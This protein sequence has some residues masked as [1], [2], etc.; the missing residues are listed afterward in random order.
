MR[1]NKFLARAGIASR[2]KSDELIQMATTTVN[3]KVCLDPAYKVDL[4]D[5]ICFD[6]KK[7]VISSKK[8]VLILNKPKKVITTVK[9]THGRQTVMDFVPSKLRLTPVGRLD[10]NTTGL[11]L[12][13]NDGDL[14]QYLTHPKNKVPKDYE[15]LIEGKID[16]KHIQKLKSGIYIGYKEYGK[17]EVLEQK[18]I[19][20]RSKIILRMKQGKKRE[21]R[22]IF[23]RLNK[24]LISLKRIGYASIKLGNLSEG[25]CRQLTKNEIN[26]LYQI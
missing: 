2:R 15:V 5:S 3:G 21:I 26:D 17:G 13:T 1:L 22:R 8:V 12:L 11:L 25:E 9:D 7:V 14:Q 6:G 4:K 10:Q 20:G 19:K 24:K 18:T 23:H 16:M